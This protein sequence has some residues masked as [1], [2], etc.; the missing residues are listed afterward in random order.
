MG[1]A[2]RTPRSWEERLRAPEF[3]APMPLAAMALLVVNDYALKPRF[4][5]ALTGKLSDVAVC[6]ALPA[7]IS[8]IV[9][10]ALDQPLHRR[11]LF[12]G[13]LTAL[14]FVALEIPGPLSREFV[15]LA[16]LLG[17]PLGIHRPFRLTWDPTDLLC[18]P[19][20]FVTVGLRFRGLRR[21]V[22]EPK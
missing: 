15:R 4:S 19:L 5:N 17:T 7:F 16:P 21:S 3:F 20:A 18:V 12:G 11:L 13:C 1:Q 8:A 14:L 6:L 22:E 2:P 9:G 10:L